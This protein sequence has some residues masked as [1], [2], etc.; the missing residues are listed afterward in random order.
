MKEL[1]ELTISDVVSSKEFYD[2]LNAIVE[3]LRQSRRTARQTMGRTLGSHVIESFLKADEW[4]TDKIIVLFQGVL[5]RQLEG[6]SA[7]RRKFIYD[8]GMEAFSKVMKRKMRNAT[9][10][11]L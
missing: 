1:K 3:E 6:Y 11:K 5:C 4:H 8:C 9:E 7:S 10:T 2:E